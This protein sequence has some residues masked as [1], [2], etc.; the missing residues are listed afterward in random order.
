[1]DRDLLMVA[2]TRVVLSFHVSGL[3]RRIEGGIRSSDQDDDILSLTVLHAAAAETAR[4]ESPA[5]I[6]A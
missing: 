3:I 5:L 6:L 2:T 4:M 1:M